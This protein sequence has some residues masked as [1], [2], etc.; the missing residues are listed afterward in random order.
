MN[1]NTKPYMYKHHKKTW[2]APKPWAFCIV[3][4]SDVKHYPISPCLLE[5]KTV[6]TKCKVKFLKSPQWFQ[7]KASHLAVRTNKQTNKIPKQSKHPFFF[8][9]NR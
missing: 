6:S 8:F 5:D 9:F 7:G 3:F 4:F 1:A 2:S